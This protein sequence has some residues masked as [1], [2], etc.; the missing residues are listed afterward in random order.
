[1]HAEARAPV[2][3]TP[4]ATARRRT[5]RLATECHEQTPGR[6]HRRVGPVGGGMGFTIG[7]IREM[8]SGSRRRGRTAECTAVAEYTG[9][10]GWDV[11]PGA[12]AAAGGAA[13]AA[14]PDCAA[15]G[16]PS[17]RLRPRGP[18]G[19]HAGRGRP[20]RGREVPGAA[21]LLPVGRTFDV[22]DVAGRPGRRA[23]VR[24][25][26]MGLPLGPVAVTPDGRAQFFVAPG[27]RRRTAAAALPDGLGRRG[28]GPACLG[29]GDHITAPPSDPAASARCAGCGRRPWTRRRRRRRRGCCWAPWRTSATARAGLT[30]RRRAG[31]ARR[32]SPTAA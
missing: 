13:P 15:P 19:R 3:T 1:M 9:L 2:R 30:H 29:P 14:T 4:R 22:L 16:R 6:N 32:R 7:G 25:E 11:V 31:R 5:H 26:R 17:A 8:R 27:R 12:R 18:R 23:L 20:R 10:W 24:L 21:V 28:P